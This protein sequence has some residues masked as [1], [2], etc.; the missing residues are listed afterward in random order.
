M[1]INEANQ[2]Y[3]G[4]MPHDIRKTLIHGSYETYYV[5]F[6]LTAERNLLQRF[7]DILSSVCV[8]RAYA[9][10]PE[11]IKSKMLW[12]LSNALYHARW[13]AISSWDCLHPRS[14]AS[15]VIAL[16]IRTV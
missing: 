6:L 16:P 2:S 9:A 10:Y 12:T 13:A 4:I 11:E 8:W 7:R 5:S 15:A 14:S 1:N 3:D